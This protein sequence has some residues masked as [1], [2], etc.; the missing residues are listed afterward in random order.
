MRGACVVE[1]ERY[2]VVAYFAKSCL[3]SCFRAYQMLFRTPQRFIRVFVNIVARDIYIARTCISSSRNRDL[4]TC[5]CIWFVEHPGGNCLW[6]LVCVS[7][8]LPGIDRKLGPYVFYKVRIMQNWWNCVCYN[9]L[10][11][12]VYQ[13]AS[14]ASVVY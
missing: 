8:R 2:N 14:V 12:Y 3:G 13:W 1:D 7:Y 4:I 11:S 5:D 9:E 6:V 10:E